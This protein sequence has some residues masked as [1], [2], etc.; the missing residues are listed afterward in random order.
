VNSWSD[1]DVR[2]LQFAEI[3]WA[4]K[5][6][7]S[8]HSSLRVYC[9]ALRQS[10]PPASFLQMLT[11]LPPNGVERPREKTI[12]FESRNARTVLKGSH[13]AKERNYWISHRSL[14]TVPYKGYHILRSRP[15]SRF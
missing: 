13:L 3:F 4:A 9:A 2:T 10:L 5:L 6:A 12:G 15:H 11:G 14:G 1:P 8:R 7:R